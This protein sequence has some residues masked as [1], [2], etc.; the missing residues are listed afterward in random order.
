MQIKLEKLLDDCIKELETIK[1]KIKDNPEVGTIDI[2]ISKKA[3][4]RYG[5]CK[6]ESPNKKYF[7][8][9]KSKY[10]KKIVYDRFNIH[11]IEISQ[12]VMQLDDQTIKN[13]IIHEILHCLPACN[14]HGVLFKSYAKYINEKLGYNI[15]RLGNKEADFKRNNLEYNENTKCYKY[16]IICKEC[17]QVFYRQRM[18]KNLIKK[19][20]CSLC[21][22]RLEL[23]HQEK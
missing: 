13:T 23:N 7:H 14:N 20:C 5:C 18:K 10:G 1:F 4:K 19:Y 6:H 17:G 9:I 11:H 21:G 12:W 15:S 22:G 16:K 2:K 8:T 3:T